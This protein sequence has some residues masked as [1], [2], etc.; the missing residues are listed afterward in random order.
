M[1]IELY[2]LKKTRLLLGLFFLAIVV[3]GCETKQ[4]QFRFSGRT[5]GT[6]YSIAIVSENNVKTDCV[7]K[8]V[9]SVLV[10]I[11]R[12]MSTYIS[13]SEISQFNHWEST[14]PFEVSEDF[15]FVVHRA[16]EISKLTEGAFDITIMPIVNLWGFFGARQD[17]WTPPTTQRLTAVLE[18]IGSDKLEVNGNY[19]RKAH[20]KLQIDVNAIAKG[21]GVDKVFDYLLNHGFDRC[22]VEIGGEVRCSGKNQDGN[23]WQIGID[24]PSYGS[25]PGRDLQ[26]VISLDNQAMATSGDYRNFV[27]WNG[28]VFS[29]A[30]D[31][32]TGYPVKMNVSSA[33]VMATT[34]LEAD[35]LAT[36]LM[37]MGED[38]GK[39]L[40]KSLKD[41]ECVLII[42]EGEDE[43]RVVHAQ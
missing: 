39:K 31:P 40:I 8:S 24:K 5:M 42:S 37:V 18:N 27:E 23:V 28:E 36:A 26:S 41:V 10:E 35:A 43:F 17:D 20:P 12:Q 33:T 11:N 32:R 13:G 2:L 30:I 4:N 15:A 7:Q 16:I 21:F 34:C 14:K 38:A 1:L 22:L 3:I 29:H 9:D 25:L 19:L 6:T